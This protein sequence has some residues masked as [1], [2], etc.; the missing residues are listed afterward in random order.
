MELSNGR[1]LEVQCTEKFLSTV[2]EYF[3]LADELEVTNEH[4]K[5]FFLGSLSNALDKL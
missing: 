4:I 3:N 1:V 2:K 5:N